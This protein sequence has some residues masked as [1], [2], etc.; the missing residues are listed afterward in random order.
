MSV[1]LLNWED[2][3]DILRERCEMLIDEYI[4]IKVPKEALKELV[5]HLTELF[6][7]RM[8]YHDSLIKD[9]SSD[10]TQETLIDSAV[11]NLSEIIDRLS[12]EILLRSGSDDEDDDQ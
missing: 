10:G 6:D 3:K 5:K 7:N 9:K 4:K 11:E 2:H 12:A 8:E 1:S